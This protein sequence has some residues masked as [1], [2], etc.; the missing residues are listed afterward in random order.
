[1]F[2]RRDS[3]IGQGKQGPPRTVNHL[4]HIH[5]QMVGGAPAEGRESGYMSVSEMHLAADALDQT[6]N[7]AIKRFRKILLDDLPFVLSRSLGRIK[8]ALV[9][10]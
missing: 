10:V 4:C 9:Q 3:W 5:K 6:P 2:G 7:E 1:M 8:G